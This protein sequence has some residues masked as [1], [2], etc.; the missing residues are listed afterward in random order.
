MNKQGGNILTEGKIFS[1]ENLTTQT[2]E[3]NSERDTILKGKSG[4]LLHIY[5]NSFID[6]NGQKISGEIEIELKEAIKSSDIILSG[7]T[8]TS[9]GLFLES[10]GMIYINASSNGN[11]LEISE[12]NFIGAIVPCQKLVEGMKVYEGEVD[13]NGINWINPSS[14]LND[15]IVQQMHETKSDTIEKTRSEKY[16]KVLNGSV[17]EIDS[18]IDYVELDTSTFKDE[19]R[20]EG[21]IKQRKQKRIQ[22]NEED[23]FISG[24]Q[25]QKGT[26][27]FNEDINTHYILSL[28]KLG[29][30]NIDR[31]FDDIRTKEVEFITKIENSNYYEQ[32]Y[33][34]LIVTK[35]SMYIPGYQRKDET[36]SFTHFDDELPKLPVGESAIILVT[37]YKGNKVYYSIKNFIITEKQRIDIILAETTNEKLKSEVKKRL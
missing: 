15:R 8:T 34:T 4:T 21:N 13:S 32:I 1:I 35:M 10:G 28:K 3:I 24:L 17:N 25:N 29:W 26:N 14:I 7:L 11:R 27:S 18:I 20:V 5:K 6:S 16:I 22:V 23:F 2:F 31:L 33:I 19:K 37:A 30:A 9:N 36:Y 12:G